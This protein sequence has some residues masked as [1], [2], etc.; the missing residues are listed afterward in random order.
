[1]NNI[2]SDHQKE[3]LESL[4]Q[5]I[6]DSF[7]FSG[8]TAIAAYYLHHRLS[9]DL[10]FVALKLGQP[11]QFNALKGLLSQRYDIYSANKEKAL[12][13]RRSSSATGQ[14]SQSERSCRLSP[15][16]TTAPPVSRSPA[17]LANRFSPWK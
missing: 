6:R 1:M 5:S 12:A 7:A 17:T 9:E 10:D 4:P 16:Y 15:P 11:V 3:V 8:G 13:A 2:L 14:T